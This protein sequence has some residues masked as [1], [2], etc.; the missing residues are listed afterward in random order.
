MKRRVALRAALGTCAWTLAPRARAQQP[1]KL[2]LVAILAFSSPQTTGWVIDDLKRALRE[3]GWIEGGNIAYE[4]RWAEGRVERLPAIARELVALRPDVIWTA[5][6][7]GAL[8]ARQATSTIPI[9]QVGADP[10]GAGLAQSLARPG[11]N[12][13]GL[14]NINVDIGPKLLELLRSGVPGAVRIGVLWNPDNPT[15]LLILTKLRAGAASSSVSALAFEART[16]PEIEQALLR[17]SRESIDG[18]IVLTDGLFV[19]HGR[20]IG[21]LLAQYRLPSAVQGRAH[22]VL[23]GM[24]S[25]AVSIQELNR[26]GAYYIDRIL[27]GAKPADLPIEQPTRFELIINLK[28]AKALGITIPQALLLRADEVI[29]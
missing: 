9:V 8:A 10:V 29:Q 2:R 17:M 22:L 4:T 14:S 11:G 25:Y 20:R 28:V 1:A 15:N 24:L 6:T 16:L 21:E 27:K 26:R 19:T 5:Y 23:G 3:L 18:V 12:V 7:S 13:T